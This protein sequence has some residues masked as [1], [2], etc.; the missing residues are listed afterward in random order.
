M[1]EPEA[2]KDDI[3]KVFNHNPIECGTKLRPQQIY[4]IYN[5]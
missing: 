5:Y 3:S 1:T 2:T 4:L